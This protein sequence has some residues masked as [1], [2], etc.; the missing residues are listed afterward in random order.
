PVEVIAVIGGTPQ[1]ALGLPSPDHDVSR[2]TFET[3]P[4]DGAAGR[5]AGSPARPAG[6]AV[7]AYGGAARA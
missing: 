4:V 1:P 7:R 5:P 3:L 6:D 2:Q